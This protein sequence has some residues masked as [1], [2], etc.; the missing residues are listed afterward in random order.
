L[1]GSRDNKIIIMKPDTDP[2]T[3]PFAAPRCRS[4]RLI[5]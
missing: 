5:S 3:D 4:P 2:D 1:S